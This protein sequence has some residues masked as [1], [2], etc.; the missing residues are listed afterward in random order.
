MKTKVF[1][2]Q[3]KIINKASEKLGSEA[4][5]ARRL[6]IYPQQLS[7]YSTGAR[8]LPLHLYLSIKI[9]LGEKDGN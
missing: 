3:K 5:L 1:K 8:E 4:S 7:R 6:K 9:I 2:I